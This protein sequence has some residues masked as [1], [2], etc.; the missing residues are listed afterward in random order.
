MKL[1]KWREHFAKQGPTKRAVTPKNI[2][3]HPL[4]TDENQAELLRKSVQ[5]VD[6]QDPPAEEDLH[7]AHGASEGHAAQRSAKWKAAA[8]NLD[9]LSVSELDFL[10]AS[11][12]PPAHVT[13]PQ[14][15]P[16]LLNMS[17]MNIYGQL[18]L[19]YSRA[20]Q[21]QMAC[22]FV[23]MEMEDHINNLEDEKAK[24]LEQ[25][26]AIREMHDVVNKIEKQSMRMSS[27]NH[28]TADEIAVGLRHPTVAKHMNSKYNY[29][30]LPSPVMQASGYPDIVVSVNVSRFAK[31]PRNTSSM[32]GLSPFASPQ[33]SEIHSQRRQPIFHRRTVVTSQPHQGHVRAE[34]KS[35]HQGHV[36]AESK[37]NFEDFTKFSVLRN[38]NIEISDHGDVEML[39]SIVKQMQDESGFS[40][41]LSGQHSEG[42][43]VGKSVP[44]A[45]IEAEGDGHSVPPQ[46]DEVPLTE[47]THDDIAD[48]GGQAEQESVA[49][50]QGGESVAPA[51][52][53]PG[54]EAE[55]EDSQMSDDQYDV[56]DMRKLLDEVTPPPEDEQAK[57]EEDIY[58]PQNTQP[59]KGLGIF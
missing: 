13:P 58:G 42:A 12:F 56:D 57:V 7:T 38:D 31:V 39:D 22:S 23:R 10:E 20:M 54:W 3:N 26:K 34:S 24:L 50:A 18:D 9:L 19:M 46:R 37:S 48:D 44:P 16:F 40:T 28:T 30:K 11:A 41:G 2:H 59:N 52:G 49:P 36:R 35:P 1:S 27:E 43:A 29:L 5:M 45:D 47:D 53:R 25:A 55:Y 8:E 4:P 17:Q 51:Q 6:G 14:W 33:L 15:D 32:S 21:V